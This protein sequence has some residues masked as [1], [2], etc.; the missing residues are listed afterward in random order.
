MVFE[1]YKVAPDW[2]RKKCLKW[3]EMGYPVLGGGCYDSSTTLQ[4]HF[5]LTIA[6]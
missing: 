2:F 6:T 1:W 3:Q 4:G 5:Q